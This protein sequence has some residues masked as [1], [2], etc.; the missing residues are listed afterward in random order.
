MKN[1][2]KIYFGFLLLVAALFLIP[3]TKGNAQTNIA[4][5]KFSTTTGATYTPITGTA[6]FSGTWDSNVSTALPLGGTFTYG[7]VAY[8]T[9]YVSSNGFL[10]F[11]AVPSTT[12]Y[13]P[14][15]STAATVLGVIAA[16]AQDGASSTVTG[17]TPL[18]SYANVGTEF[19]VQFQDHSNY[20]NRSVERLNFQIRLDLTSNAINIVYGSCTNPGTVST[21]GTSAI[22][23]G[24]RGNSNTWSSNVNNLTVGNVPS[25]T[26]CNW[27]DAVTGNTANDSLLFSGTTNV[28]V[29]INAGLT[30]TWTPATAVA[31]VRTFSAVTAITANS[32][33]LSWTAPTGATQYNVQYRALGTC[34]WTNF[35]GNPVSTN[36]V[37]FTGL[38]TAT[39]YQVR[40]QSSDGT[41][42]AI[43]SHLPN[44]L[45]TGD[46]YTVAGTFITLVTCG[47]PTSLT[48]PAATVTPTSIAFNWVAPTIGTPS[49]YVWEIRTAG[50]AGSGASGLAATGTT[51]STSVSA[52]GLTGATAYTVYVRTD[53]SGDLGTWASATVTTPA[54]MSYVSST[55][56][57]PTTTSVSV[58]STDVGTIRIAVAVI[59]TVNP[60]TLTKLDLSTNGTTN[61][62]DLTNAKVYYTGTSTTLTT[63]T[64]F[65]TPILSPNGSYSV[66][67][68]QV[69]T[70]GTSN[71]TNYFWVTYDVACAAIVGD[72]LDAECSAVTIS[73]TAYTPT[74]TAPAF[75]KRAVATLVATNQPS[76]AGVTSGTINVQVL[77]VDV[78]VNSCIGDVTTLNFSNGSN[79]FANI[80]KARVYYTTSTTFATTTQ[81]GT[82]IANPGATFSVT[83]TQASAASGTNYYWL[84]YDIACS[85]PAAAA[86]SADAGCTSVIG[87]TSTTFV[88]AI[89]NP[90]GKRVITAA[91]FTAATNQPLTS[92][93]T[94]GTVNAQVLRVD[95][96]G[97]ACVGNITTLNFTNA[98]TNVADIAK[99]KVFYTTTTTFSNAVQFGS[100]VIAPGATFSVTGSQASATSG[101]NYFWLVYDIGCSAPSAAANVAD[102]SL[103]SVATST[104]STLTPTT[105]NPTGTRT[106]TTATAYTTVAN[107]EWSNSSTWACG[108]VPPTN[109]SSIVIASNVTVSDA[110]PSN[111]G[112]SVTVNSG[113]SLT[114][115]TGGILT[116]G[117]VGGGKITLTNNGTLT[118]SGGV[119]NVN[120]NV[121][122]AS[123]SIFNQTGG[124]INVDGNDGTTAGSVA[125]SADLFGIGTGTTNYASGTINVTGGNINIIDPHYAGTA[126]SSGGAAFAFR[127]SS[128]A[129]KSFSSSHTTRFGGTTGTNASTAAFEFMVD[130]YVNGAQLIFGNVVASG[131]TAAR[132]LQTNC[133]SGGGGLVVGGN[134]TIE[135]G[136]E[137]LDTT[138]A[139]QGV[140]LIGN[141]VNNGVFTQKNTAG[142]QLINLSGT[143]FTSIASVTTPQSIG[144]AGLFRN[145]AGA[146][147]ANLTGMTVNN[148]SV[149]GVTMNVPANI[150]GTLTLSIGKVNTTTTNL[151][152]LGYNAANVGSLTSSA[153]SWVNGPFKRWIDITS[154]AS[155]AFPVGGADSLELA[156]IAY[157]TAAALPTTGGSLT[158]RWIA[159]APGFPNATP[160]VEPVGPL[161]INAA[162]PLGQWQIDAGDGLTG[163]TYTGTFSPKGAANVLDYTKLVLLKRPS[164]GGDWT[165][166]G[167]HTVTSG[168]NIA[169]VLSRTGMTGFSQFA[170]GGEASVALPISVQYFTGV[171][172]TATNTLNWKVNCYSTPSVT[173]VL[174]RGSNGRSFTAIN[175]ITASALRCDLPFTY[176]DAQPLAGANYYRLK[177]IDADGKVSYSGV[178]VLLNKEKGLEIVSINPNPVT[179][180]GMFKLN[181]TSAQ[182]TKLNLVIVDMQGRIVNQQVLAVANGFNSLTVNVATLSTGTYQV[183]GTSSEGK[184]K[185]LSFVKQ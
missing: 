53:C 16:F 13:V 22:Q 160:L 76:T 109:A 136:S 70:G 72:S 125:I 32:A 31:P 27:D 49:G 28:N 20:F 167:T 135:A 121:I 134:L 8:T 5:Y 99:A 37:T 81:F 146:V 101:T 169:P 144:G 39:T 181:V 123:A 166:D 171:K 25:G 90:N 151:L 54:F 82:E 61:V 52:S 97:N 89:T 155:R 141:L 131:G 51:S 21:A 174:E 80:T 105:A 68:S 86:D 173:L 103:V 163:G 48:I 172:A 62:T 35:S 41:N 45:G 71:T 180:D 78:P 19:V 94:S 85:A 58:G 1:M 150:S 182:A 15:S 64:L 124:D 130:C 65:G 102:A 2:K 7:G 114:I 159:G 100:D 112:G 113:S 126:T 88:P 9:C 3:A 138:V 140:R 43:W 176:S 117:P 96:T 147:T 157:P 179:V 74:I 127:A 137:L 18:V 67:G 47:A 165:L 116:L 185:V 148:S 107:G 93:V 177:M 108:T 184:T 29:K 10:T 149:A 133:V 23:V 63:T 161:V 115:N 111:I 120:G 4:N 30:Y 152:T 104:I 170:I 156:T 44:A 153:T 175:S 34:S 73:G 17:S 12:D 36:S 145:S 84:V 122:I 118:V 98:S 14:L 139:A 40:V 110:L 162:A 158:A 83:G 183:Y 50:A 178:V 57:Q 66:T 128:G 59:G 46:G 95:I 164:A 38:S 129:G 142:L 154:T 6:I 26:T 42:N 91:T 132:R 60:L 119:L 79:N 55:T 24:L 11:G 92:G 168:T 143:S 33:T 75:S 87:S 56:A 77:R 106:I 69:L